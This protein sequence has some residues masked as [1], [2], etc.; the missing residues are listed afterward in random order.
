MLRYAKYYFVV[1]PFPFK[2]GFFGMMQKY[3]KMIY[4]KGIGYEK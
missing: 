2:K 4:L 1:F 3:A